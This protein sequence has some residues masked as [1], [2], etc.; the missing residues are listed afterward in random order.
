MIPIKVTNSHRLAKRHAD[1]VFAYLKGYR[2]GRAFKII[3]NWIT[4]QFGNSY[5]LKKI[6]M[7][8]P[9]HLDNL[10]KVYRRRKKPIPEEII[11][12]KNIYKYFRTTATTPFLEADG[13]RYDGFVFAKNLDLT[14]CPYCN[15][16]YIFNLPTIGKA[17]CELDHFYNKSDFPFLALSFYNLI[18]S[19]K[20]CNHIKSNGSKSYYNLHKK[21]L[22]ESELVKFSVKITGA[23][24]LDDEADLRLDYDVHKSYQDTFDDLKFKEIY[25]R[26]KD[27]VQDLI[28][29]QHLYSSDYLEQLIKDYQGKLF[30][31]KEELI[32]ILL[33]GNVQPDKLCLKPFSKL[34]KDIWEQISEL[35]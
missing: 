1:I 11:S 32:S 31:N 23:S 20:T 27:Q 5:N 25:D 16:N 3:N 10:V 8:D 28:K 26:H 9:G 34:T 6:L 24:Y 4:L 30:R 21:D 35:R 13:S 2:Y 14:V 22:T 7:A 17:T 18:P 33:S 12:F 15:R 29:K 19:C